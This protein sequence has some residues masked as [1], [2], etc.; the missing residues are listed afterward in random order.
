MIYKVLLTFFLLILP[1]IA[2]VEF[3][4]QTI[5]TDV[6]IV[7]DLAAVDMN[8][9]N[10]IDFVTISRRDSSIVWYQNDGLGQFTSRMIASPEARPFRIHTA[11]IDGD[12]DIDLVVAM[13]DSAG[14]IWYENEGEGQFK[15][16]TIRTSNA[17][18]RDI[19]V[20]DI[21]GDND[22]DI[23]SAISGND[24]VAWSEND[25]SGNFTL[26]VLTTEAL[27][28]QSVLAIDLDSDGDQDVLSASWRDTMIRWYENDGS[29]NFDIHIIAQFR[30][31]PSQLTAF[32][33]DNDG[34]IDV[35][36]NG[37]HS[38]LR[39]RGSSL[40][41]LENNGKEVFTLQPV[42]PSVS[43][44][45]QLVT[46]D[47]NGDQAVDILISWPGCPPLVWYENDPDQHFKER[48]ITL[49]HFVDYPAVVD[50][51]QDGDDDVVGFRPH[52]NTIDFYENQGPKIEVQRSFHYP[53]E[54]G[55]RWEFIEV[56]SDDL[57]SR[58]VV[59]DTVLPSG[60]SY[61]MIL[62]ERIGGRTTRVDSI[63]QR[64]DGQKVFEINPWRVSEFLIY[65]FSLSRGEVVTT[66]ATSV[67]TTDI[68]VWCIDFPKLF[69][70]KL[71]RWSFF[72]DNARRFIDD[73]VIYEV[74]DSLGMTKRN[75]IE[76]DVYELQ[77]AIVGGVVYDIADTCVAAEVPEEPPVNTVPEQIQLFQNYPNPFNP[78]TKIRYDIAEPNRVHLKVFDV[79]GRHVVTLVNAYQQP[80][81]YELEFDGSN[82]ASGIYIYRLSVGRTNI[83]RKMVLMR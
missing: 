51:D 11:D 3:E 8:G 37:L 70:R 22:I 20:A 28:V 15:E 48:A 83:A 63:Y 64:L 79:S 46:A 30:S 56:F 58:T 38:D 31:S 50:F 26:H 23:L 45:E 29:E 36:S 55:D 1:A 59:G 33:V 34:D 39:Y 74:T 19:E 69:C 57:V 61:K 35:F 40:I 76:G 32:D 5:I 2:Q 12:A 47:F 6:G 53:L 7:S 14:I 42:Y 21:D 13:L 67:D 80:G 66:F 82:L 18:V 17:S 54:V 68:I 9:D 16:N 27:R 75:G 10:D 25:G 71:P 72:V 44:V 4:M 65:D 41:W 43:W 81:E 60:L 73:E 52:F 49:T 77:R 62:Q 24:E 78:G